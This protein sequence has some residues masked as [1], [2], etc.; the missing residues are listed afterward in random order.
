[1]ELAEADG[2][3]VTIRGPA[4]DWTC[5]REIRL[6]L[7][8]TAERPY[9]VTRLSAVAGPRPARLLLDTLTA[10]TPPTGF[11]RTVGAPDPIVATAAQVRSRPWRFAVQ[12]TDAGAPGADFA[13]TGAG[14]PAFVH[15][16]VRFLPLDARLRTLDGGGLA[17]ITALRAALATAAREPGTGAV[18]LVQPY[19]PRAVDHKEAALELRYLAEFRRTTGKRAAVITLEAPRFA[20]GRT[21]GVLTLATPRTGRTLIGADA[22]AAGDWLSVLPPELPSVLSR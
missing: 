8:A 13:L 22:F 2:G 15:R 16:G 14:R 9:T 19:A 5:W 21:E 12:P 17:R 11:V 3:V 1:M 20:A 6:P 7:P 10:R 4:V 18:A